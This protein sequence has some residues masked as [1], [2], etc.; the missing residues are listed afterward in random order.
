MSETESETEEPQT[1]EADAAEEIE[2][3]LP[4]F[5]EEEYIE[6]EI[7]DARL[8]IA[9]LGYSAVLGLVTRFVHQGLGNPGFGFIFGLVAAYGL[10]PLF[11][12]IGADISEFE[13]KN[14]LALGGIYF[15]AWLG[16]WTLFLNPP[17]V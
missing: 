12:S 13:A 6:Q 8:A 2:F 4:E 5:D 14:W 11:E 1:G 7:R 15:F 10:K 9:T 17:F 3:E 16:F